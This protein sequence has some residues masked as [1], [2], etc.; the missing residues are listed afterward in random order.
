[1]LEVEQENQ[2]LKEEVT[3]LKAMMEQMSTQLAQLMAARNR[4]PTPP[5][6]TQAQ[7]IVSTA[8]TSTTP[9]T[10]PEVRPWG[11]PLNEESRPLFAGVSTTVTKQNVTLPQVTATTTFAPPLVHSIPYQEHEQIYHT[12]SVAGY[13]QVE[14][15]RERFEGKFEEMQKEMRVLRGKE[16][17]GQEAHELCLVPDVVIPPKFKV[18]VFDKYEGDTCP[19][20]HLTMYARKMSHQTKNDK[21]LIYYFQESLTGAALR[22]YGDLENIRTFHDLANAF[23]QQYKYN[24]YLA[25]DRE[26]LRSLTQRDK[27]SFKEYAQRW[28]QLAAQIRPPLEERELTKLFLNTLGSPYFEK[29]IGS[30]SHDFTEMVGMGMRIEEALR[31]GRLVKENAPASNVK[32]YG[33]NFQKRKEQ[34]VSMIAHGGPQP[35]YPKYHHIAAIPPPTNNT[36]N[37]N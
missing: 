24:L 20:A 27:E 14:D 33:N 29:M 25:P 31:D 9:F 30:A 7:A 23:V 32:K 1:M 34:E 8:P 2:Q 35:H 15:L 19:K 21:L 12:D 4:P 26:E 36:Q 6:L 13:D 28:R 11:M 18:P 37:P 3:S 16:V 10:I 5:P 22:W 17:F